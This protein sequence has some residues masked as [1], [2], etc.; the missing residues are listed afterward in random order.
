MTDVPPTTTPV[1]DEGLVRAIGTRAL[2]LNI[3]NMVIGAGIFVLPGLVAVELG[4]AAVVAYF[5]CSVAV[6]LV[7][8]CFAEAGSR[9]SLSGGAY[10]YIED[11]FGPFARFLSSILL[12]FGWGVLSIAAVGIALTEMVALAIPWFGA[13]IPKALFVILLFG[14]LA[15]VNVVGVKAGVR[16]A[17]FNTYAKLLPLSVLIVLGVFAVQWENLAITTWPSLSSIGAGT[18]LLIFAFG[19][20]EIA[21]NAGGEIKDPERTVPKGL[22]LGL[23]SIFMLYLSIQGIAQGVLGRELVTNTEAPLVATAEAAL[24]PC[25]KTLLLIGAGISIFGVISGDLLA[26]PRAVFAGAR[27][28]L[29]P[30]RLGAVHPRFKTPYLAILFYS[31]LACGF[32]LSGT[33]KTL[34]VVSSGSVLLI[35]L[36]CSLAVLQLRRQGVQSKGTVFRVPGGPVVPVLSTLVVVWLLSNMTRAEAIGLGVLLVAASLLYIGQR[37]FRKRNQP[38]LTSG[39]ADTSL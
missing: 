21:L 15:A 31:A 6:G 36:G 35:Y 39:E 20:A 17:V 9:I 16:F 13:P 34:A 19:G 7:F 29:L 14:T 10:A 12:W 3:I 18:L 38:T 1:T 26:S 2:G 5:V 27:N 37:A 25:G 33:L 8:L 28:G 22:F 11:A 23:G 30:A 4:S 32:A 24:G